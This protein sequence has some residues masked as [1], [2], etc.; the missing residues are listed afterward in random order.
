MPKLSSLLLLVGLALAGC[1]A[2]PDEIIPAA[3][4][5]GNP[6]DPA[7]PVGVPPAAPGLLTIAPTGRGPAFT[8]A[9]APEPVLPKMDAAWEVREIPADLEGGT[10]A[11]EDASERGPLFDADAPAPGRKNLP[12]SGF[13][14]K[15]EETP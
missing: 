15:P 1:S 6:A 3:F 2:G 7:D 13:A 8:A 4:A 9:V 14:P 10:G 11:I 12:R 5:A